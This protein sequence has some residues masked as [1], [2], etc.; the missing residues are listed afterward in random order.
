MPSALELEEDVFGIL[1]DFIDPY[2]DDDD[3]SSPSTDP[4][5]NGLEAVCGVDRPKRKR[6]K[7]KKN[8][9]PRVIKSDIRRHYSTMITNVIN[10]NNHE[11]LKSFFHSYAIPTFRMNTRQID[12]AS[13]A[14]LP[15]EVVQN[16]IA[17]FVKGISFNGEEWLK[18]HSLVNNMISPDQVLRLRDV[19]LVTRLNDHR[20]VIVM[21][22]DVELSHIFEVD[23]LEMLN[24]AFDFDN[25]DDEQQERQSNNSSPLFSAIDSHVVEQPSLR[26]KL[27]NL[28]T[29]TMELTS[30]PSSPSA[31]VTSAVAPSDTISSVPTTA[32]AA[33]ETI[34]HHHNSHKHLLGP[35]LVPLSKPRQYKMQ[36]EMVLILGEDKRIE[37]VVVGDGRLAP[38]LLES[39]DR[40]AAALSIQ[41]T[42]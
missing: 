2:N 17:K 13:Y 26:G 4:G 27:R 18:F 6:P 42:R 25:S 39:L 29:N 15:Q 40:Q 14:H 9:I 38:D 32:V 3:G 16:N 20:S 33:T 35:S 11:L 22:V 12:P 34:R 31:L 36:T 37:S 23:P 30:G 21:S 24:S 1:S 19:R 41:S 28:S 7:R 8:F 5:R 10:A